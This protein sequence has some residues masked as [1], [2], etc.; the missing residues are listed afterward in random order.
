MGSVANLPAAIG[1]LRDVVGPQAV[2]DPEIVAS[3]TTDWTGRFV[4]D[5]PLVV[6]PESTEQVAGV[7]SVCRELGLSLVPQGGNT[8][9]VGGGVPLGGEVVL[10]L[11]RL[12]AMEP[13]DVTVRPGHRRSRHRPR[14]APTGG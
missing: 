2:A 7:V 8:G 11:C 5:S 9:L 12:R 6:R 10:S 14:P 4:G 1:R 3:Y 13:V